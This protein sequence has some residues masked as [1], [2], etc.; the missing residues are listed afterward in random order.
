MD[1]SLVFRP[2]QLRSCWVPPT[3]QPD[4]RDVVALCQSPGGRFARMLLLVTMG[5]MV[6][7][8][9]IPNMYRT[10]TDNK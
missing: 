5:R 7:F 1:K 6:K 2:P 8:I 10:S 4:L 3:A 9:G